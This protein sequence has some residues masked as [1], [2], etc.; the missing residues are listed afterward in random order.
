VKRINIKIAPGDDPDNPDTREISKKYP[1]TMA[2]ACKRN[3]GQMKLWGTV[4][5]I[6]GRKVAT[7]L[8]VLFEKYMHC[9]PK[10]KF[11]TCAMY[12]GKSLYPIK[13]E[14]DPLT[15]CNDK[16]R[17]SFDD[18]IIYGDLTSKIPKVKPY[19]PVC[20][21]DVPDSKNDEVIVVGSDAH[22]FKG[23]AKLNHGKM[24]LV[25]RGI[26]YEKKIDY[27]GT[28]LKYSNDTGEGTSGG[29]ILMEIGG[30][31][32]LVGIHKGDILFSILAEESGLRG[33]RDGLRSDEENNYS[34]GLLFEDNSKICLDNAS[35]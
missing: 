10:V 13:W 34:Q 14:E 31:T 6:S 16:I 4:N 29:A 21:K 32:V 1:G 25:S 18:V 28:F 26:S 8:H 11:N 3:D 12:D 2:L 33:T 5:Y 17:S 22:N 27:H 23:R 35:N 9:E 7:I 15:I 30:K 20:E 19:T 24:R